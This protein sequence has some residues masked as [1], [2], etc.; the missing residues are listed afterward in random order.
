[1]AQQG[2]GSKQERGGEASRKA[3]KQAGGREKQVGG[4]GDN[5]EQ[6]EM[7]QNSVVGDREASERQCRTGCNMEQR[8]SNRMEV[9]Q[10]RLRTQ[11]SKLD[12][13]LL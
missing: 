11:T 12:Q 9:E 1:M 4:V 6:Q 10:K 13:T 2:Q 8:W 5:T 7:E 3:R